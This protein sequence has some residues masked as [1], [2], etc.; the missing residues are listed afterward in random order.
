[1]ND[2]R[3]ELAPVTEKAWKEIEEEATRTLKTHLAARKL[4]DFIGPLGWDSSA[5]SLGRTRAASEGSDRSIEIRRRLVRPLSELRAPFTLSREELD[6][7]DRGSRDPDLQPLIEAA[8]RLALAEDRLVFFGN[9]EAG[10]EGIVTASPHA[11]VSTGRGCCDF[12]RL[13]AEAMETLREAG[14]AGPY[15]LALDPKSYTELARTVGELGYPVIKHV[16]QLLDGPIVWAPALEHG[17]VLSLRGDDFELTVGRDVSIGYLDHDRQSVQLYL[18][19]SL[20]FRV[21]TPEAAVR[22][23]TEAEK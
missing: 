16:A 13:I 23:G 10:G 12:P 15:A 5:V 1:M 17:L 7:V 4:V 19:E 18:E 21:L 14:I 11:P 9:G 2:L 6:N 3:R 20:A 22:L 8:R